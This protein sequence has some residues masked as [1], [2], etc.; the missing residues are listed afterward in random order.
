VS[1]DA[2]GELYDGTKMDGPGGLRRALL[3]HADLFVQSFTESL[4]TYALGRRVESEDMPQVRAIARAAAAQDYRLSA[5]IVGIV[6]SPA[7]QMSTAD[8]AASTTGV[9]VPRLARLR[10][11][12]SSMSRAATPR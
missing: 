12:P 3:Q 8:P 4:M 7:F 1:I 10:L 5:F 2:A 11:A 6:N 9:A